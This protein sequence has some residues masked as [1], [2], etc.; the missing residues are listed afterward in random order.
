MENL[1]IYITIE[2]PATREGVNISGRFDLLCDFLA[3]MNK[4]LSKEIKTPLD[5]QRILDEASHIP[6][7][8]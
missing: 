1:K 8:T 5:I 3:G 4:T 7:P 6:Q 2:D